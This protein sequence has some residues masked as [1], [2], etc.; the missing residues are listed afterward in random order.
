[1]GRRGE[2]SAGA[3]QGR[4]GKNQRVEPLIIPQ[5]GEVKAYRGGLAVLVIFDA[6]EEPGE[7]AMGR[8]AGGRGRGARRHRGEEGFDG[9]GGFFNAGMQIGN[10]KLQIR[11]RLRF[12]LQFAI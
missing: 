1:M 9:E 11:R 8:G 7:A 6:I 4:D 3:A 2:L 5:L 12:I 10:C